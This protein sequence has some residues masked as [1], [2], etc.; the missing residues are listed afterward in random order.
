MQVRV[1]S[2]L[3]RPFHLHLRHI[4][5]MDLTCPCAI[6]FHLWSQEMNAVCLSSLPLSLCIPVPLAES[7]LKCSCLVLEKHSLFINSHVL[8]FFSFFPFFL[9]FFFSF[10][11]HGFPVCLLLMPPYI[12][13]CKYHQLLLFCRGV[14][15]FFFPT[16]L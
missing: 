6:R 12:L 5:R 1:L 9:F 2:R 15:V 11:P 13:P 4:L 3:Q 14:C 10:L 8:S 7:T 16:A